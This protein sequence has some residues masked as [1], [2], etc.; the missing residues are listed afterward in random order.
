MKKTEAIKLIDKT[1]WRLA[2]C[3]ESTRHWEQYVALNIEEEKGHRRFCPDHIQCGL[4]RAQSVRLFAV[5]EIFERYVPAH[6]GEKIFTPEAK[7]F[8]SI[9]HSVFAA[10]ALADICGVR[11]LKEFSE[12]E[13]AQWL[14]DVDYC[15]L[16]KDPRQAQKEAA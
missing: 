14:A 16:N 9:R 4:T 8:F 11:I 13:M 7:D 2:G 10:A 12:P 5:K 6:P 1:F 3:C 15:E